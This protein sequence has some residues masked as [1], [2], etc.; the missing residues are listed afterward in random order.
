[1][2]DS[3][4]VFYLTTETLQKAL[5]GG[6][7]RVVK[8][9]GK[10]AAIMDIT[11]NPRSIKIRGTVK[12]FEA[13]ACLLLESPVRPEFEDTEPSTAAKE[14]NVPFVGQKRL[15]HYAQF[16]VTHTVKI[17]LQI[18]PPLPQTPRCR[19]N[20]LVRLGLASTSSSLK[21]SQSASAMTTSKHSCSHPSL[22]MYAANPKTCSIV[23]RLIARI[24]TESRRLASST[25]TQIVSHLFILTA[26]PLVTMASR[27]KSTRISYRKAT[28][29]FSNGS[30]KMM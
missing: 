12:D 24:S 6:F 14:M 7:R 9:L 27:A 15:I 19:Y 23:R 1:M 16:V 18:S 4:H 28:R 25:H 13:A 3:V 26:T 17:V 8:S 11:S 22:Y 5:Q 10:E 30:G 29:R 20:V 2:K 21:N